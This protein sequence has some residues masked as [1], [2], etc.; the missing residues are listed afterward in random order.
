[1][2]KFINYDEKVQGRGL[3]ATIYE[4]LTQKKKKK[5]FMNNHNQHSFRAGQVNYVFQTDFSFAI[6]YFS[7]C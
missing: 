7:I 2:I 1:M 3:M 5:W 4:D 6:M